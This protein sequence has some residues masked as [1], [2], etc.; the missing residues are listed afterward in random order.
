ML[1]PALALAD[2]GLPSLAAAARALSS[3][4]SPFFSRSGEVGWLTQ[5]LHCSTVGGLKNLKSSALAVNK[6]LGKG[7]KLSTNFNETVTLLVWEVT[8]A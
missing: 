3:V 7:Y 6:F 2:E 8:D 4:D 1:P 5:G